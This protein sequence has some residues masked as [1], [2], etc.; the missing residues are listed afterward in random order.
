ME[1]PTILVTG[2]SGFVG[3]ALCRQLAHSDLVATRAALRSG[4]M[5]PVAAMPSVTI[6][7]L[8][9]ATDWAAA[10]AGI[11]VVVHAAARV[12][13][14]HETATDSLAEFRRVNVEGTLNLARQAAAAGV[15]RFI[16][17]SSI[18][19]NGETSQPG[20]PLRADDK[21]APQDAYGVSKH[22]AEQGLHALAASTGMEV[23]VIR[24]VLVYGPGVKANF[25]SMMRWV[26]RGVPLPLGAV[27]NR[28][29]LVSLA[30]LVDLITTCIDHP[31]AAWQTFLASDG[32][33]V[34][35]SQLLRALGQA[36][37]RPARLLPVPA[38]L[39]KTAASL[40]GRRD[41]AQRLLGSLQVD[42][43]K[44]RELLGWHPPYTLQQG[45]TLAALPFLE[46]H[47]R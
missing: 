3:G 33:D 17:I 13:V 9:A 46:A 1:R 42:I 39:L 14:M 25:L 26:H 27:H 11:H 5:A 45:L 6:K 15:R 34:S 47:H 12:H 23:V 20:S 37:G 21:P 28:R 29:S 22:E 16:F 2:A 35:L 19:V 41:L 40:L 43:T 24:P 10:L 32:D 7:D 38:A 44:N 30:N 18:K 4:A 8:D 31:A 36:M